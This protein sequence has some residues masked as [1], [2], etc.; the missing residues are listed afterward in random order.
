TP[1]VCRRPPGPPPGGA[2]LGIGPAGPRATGGSFDV[3]STGSGTF[4]IAVRATDPDGLATT[5]PLGAYDGTSGRRL[6]V[7][8]EQ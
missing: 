1:G 2:G 7:P 5:T 6:P 8:S 3:R 4:A